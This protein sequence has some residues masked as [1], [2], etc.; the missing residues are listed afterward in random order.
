MLR[1][2][3]ATS[4]KDSPTESLA[5][6]RSSERNWNVTRALVPP[7]LLSESDRDFA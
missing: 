1:V 4:V 7:R 2:R 5:A 6:L 3:P